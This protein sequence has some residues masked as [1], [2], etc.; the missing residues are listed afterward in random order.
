MSLTTD[1]CVV[2][3]GM[4]GATAA[5]LLAKLDPALTVIVVDR[6]L[7]DP[8]TNKE[9]VDVR[10]SAVS[11]ASQRVL[12]ACGAWEEVADFR[13]SPYE[14]MRVWDAATSFDQGIEFDCAEIAEPDL[15]SIVEN[16]VIQLALIR[17]M[18]SLDN[19]DLVVPATVQGLSMADDY[20]KVRLEDGRDIA[21]KLVVAADG[22][23]SKVRD[24]AAIPV[25]G[26]SYEQK[27]VVATVRTQRPHENTAWQRFLPHGPIAFLPLSDGRSSIVWSCPEDLATS[28]MEMS[29]SS[30][31]QEVTQALDD[32]LGDVCCDSPRASFPL[33]LMHAQHYVTEGLALIGDAAHVV[34]PLAGQGANLGFLDAACLAEVVGN[35]LATRDYFFETRTLR[36]YERWR[37]G[38][39]L[40]VMSLL[41][42]L[43]RLFDAESLTT[44]R[45]RGLG[46]VAGV[47]PVKNQLVRQAMG[48][49]GDLPAIARR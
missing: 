27:G 14:K 22:A 8:Y 29:E 21:C 38:E 9:N 17:Q 3:A 39:N 43:K 6:S 31:N 13:H 33:S 20:Q 4:V 10:V 23:Q 45:S 49:T 34:H 47:A 44:L 26:W 15:G 42:G 24:L 19:I 16:R 7:P 35:S 41:D 5:V 36:K 40:L 32:V 2:G 1:V 30:F 28:L 37:K 11:R 48:L 25:K 18:R 46:W 12:A